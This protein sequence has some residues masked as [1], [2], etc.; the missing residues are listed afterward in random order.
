MRTFQVGGMTV[1]TSDEIDGYTTIDDG[2][3]T[4]S[5]Y[6]IAFPNGLLITTEF[7]PNGPEHVSSLLI[8]DLS[9]PGAE[10]TRFQTGAP[11]TAVTQETTFR[12]VGDGAFVLRYFR[13]DND[14]DGSGNTLFTRASAAQWIVLTAALTVVTQGAGYVSVN[15]GSLVDESGAIL[16]TP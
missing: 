14:P 6:G 3:N 11:D 10:P 2:G 1:R 15:D 13:A 8:F 16:Y 5:C 12:F 7:T 9:Q 4:Y